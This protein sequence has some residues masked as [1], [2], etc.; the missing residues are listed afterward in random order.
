MSDSY[1]ISDDKTKLQLDEIKKL[2]EQTYWAKKRTKE[3]CAK[4]IEHSTC[5]GVY[6]QNDL[7]IG[8]ARVLTD[9]TT[10]F[11]LCDVII[12]KEHR[13]K[14]LGKR[15]VKYISEDEDFMELYGLLVTSNAHRFYEPLGFKRDS[16]IFMHKPV[17]R[18]PKI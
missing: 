13:G 6:D 1:T 16:R 5:Y 11:Y 18:I 7:Q 17:R 8:F 4:A 14:G 12:D 2:M 3:I 15:L 10:T 9:Y